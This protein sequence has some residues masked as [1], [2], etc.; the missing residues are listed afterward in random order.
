MNANE[1]KFRCSSLGHLMTEP[2]LK[3]E[4][5]AATTKTHLVDVFV[6]HKYGRREEITGKFLD[7]G[8]E[9]EEDSITLISRIKKK[10]YK[11]NSERLTN[12]FVTGEL[13]LY[14]GESVSNA[15]ETIDIK[16]SWSAHTFFRAQKAELDKMYKWQGHGYMALS[17]AKKHTVAYCL[18]NGTESA[19]QNEKRYLSYQNGMTDAGGNHSKEYTERC[20]QIEIN[21]I[22]DLE[23]FQK[24]YPWYEFANDVSK[25]TY[26]MPIE[27][28]L[29]CFEFERNDEDIA[30][31]YKRI[32]DCRIWMNENLYKIPV[33]QKDLVG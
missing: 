18:V 1:I 14:F 31:L 11:K 10:F 22:F 16:T 13:D 21:H 30:R 26:D 29:F 32:E 20:K 17:G 7:K 3:S 23:S 27:E 5:I 4:T 6:S 33:L 25:W 19:I 8:N 24:E 12:N 28:R 2:K 15:D 9:R